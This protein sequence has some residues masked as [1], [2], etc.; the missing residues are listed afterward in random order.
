M[1]MM[2]ALSLLPMVAG[3]VVME[4]KEIVPGVFQP[5]VSIGTWAWGSKHEDSKTITKNWLENG[6]RGVDTAL[7]YFDQKEV[8]QAVADEGLAREDVFITTKIPGCFATDISVD[9]DLAKL[10]TDYIDLMLLHSPVAFLPGGCKRSWKQLEKYVKDGKVKAIGVSNF[11]AKQMQSIL[12][13]ATVPIAVNQ[14]RYNPF[15]HN[16]DIISFNDAH[17]ITTMAYSPLAHGTSGRSIFTDEIIGAIATAHNVTAA[18]VALRWIVQRG[19]TMAVLSGNKEHQA[20]DADLFGFELTD[21]EMTQ[22]T[23]LQHKGAQVVV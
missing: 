4:T 22:L 14:I 3:D 7:L 12:D 16:E 1:A 21:D 2:R 9:Y 5:K 18:Q 13:H 6:F 15:N 20:N 23:E 11:N 10:G 19:H 8:M 17:N